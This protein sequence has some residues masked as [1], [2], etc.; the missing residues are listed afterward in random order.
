MLRGVSLARHPSLH[1][2][3]RDVQP[4]HA[5]SVI[6]EVTPQR[7]HLHPQAQVVVNHREATA[8][9]RSGSGP[10]T[11][12]VNKVPCK[13]AWVRPIELSAVILTATLLALRQSGKL[14]LHLQERSQPVL[15]R[16]VKTSVEI[17]LVAVAASGS[18]LAA[19]HD[20]APEGW[21]GPSGS[22]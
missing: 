8:P 11:W 4:G 16:R 18:S 21:S 5:G 12:S 9:S 1:V 14:D 13:R 19:A 22:R 17:G 3:G 15:R 6:M 2:S 7:A 10:G 20:L